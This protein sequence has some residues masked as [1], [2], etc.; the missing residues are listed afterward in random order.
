[1]LANI[2][3]HKW[4]SVRLFAFASIYIPAGVRYTGW[5]VRKYIGSCTHMRTKNACLYQESM[6]CYGIVRELWQRFG[7]QK[8]KDGYFTAQF[9]SLFVSS[10]RNWISSSFLYN[11]PV[12]SFLIFFPFFIH[13][14]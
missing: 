5:G 3:L 4:T 12:I 8:I 2:Y 14:I 9:I 6:K 1:M 10:Y 7:R 11:I 13:S